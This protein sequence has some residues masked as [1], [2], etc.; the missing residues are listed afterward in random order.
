MEGVAETQSI[1]ATSG[2]ELALCL[3]KLHQQSQGMGFD[4]R[5]LG[6]LENEGTADSVIKVHNVLHILSKLYPQHPRQRANRTLPRG[7]SLRA[8]CHLA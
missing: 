6:D 7:S 2:T 1:V 8:R 3:L 5:I 4:D